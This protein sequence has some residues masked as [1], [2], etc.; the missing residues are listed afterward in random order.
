MTNLV[1]LN[2]EE[3]FKSAYFKAKEAFLKYKERFMS[4]PN[5][6][7]KDFNMICS[8]FVELEYLQLDKDSDQLTVFKEFTRKEYLEKFEGHYLAFTKLYNDFQPKES[9]EDRERK[10]FHISDLDNEIQ[11][12]YQEAK[13]EYL[14]FLNSYKDVGDFNY[15]NIAINN[16]AGAGLDTMPFE[17]QNR[18]DK[19]YMDID[20]GE[21]EAKKELLEQLYQIKI[22][23]MRLQRGK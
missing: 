2:L 17:D 20:K 12:C 11:F 15:F 5:N 4:D 1:F 9:L 7:D 10:T 23:A 19:V 3:E 22:K 16:F 8:F 6:D 14:K 21:T 18:L 13:E